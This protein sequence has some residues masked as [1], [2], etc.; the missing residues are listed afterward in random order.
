MTRSLLLALLLAA[1]CAPALADPISIVAAIAPFIGGTAAAFIVNYAGT[2]ALTAL[3][4]F[5]SVR[6]RSKQRKLAAQAKAAY[7][8]SLQDRNVSV[9]AA[10]P[11]RRYRLGRCWGGG[12]VVAVFTTDKQGLKENGT[13]YTKADGYKHVVIVWAYHQCSAIHDLAFEGVPIGPLDVDGWAIGSHWATSRKINQSRGGLGGVLGEVI[14]TASSTVTSV[15]LIIGY[16]DPKDASHVPVPNGGTYGWSMSGLTLNLPDQILLND[17]PYTPTAA[18]R[19]EVNYAREA[20]DRSTVRVRHHL[21]EPGQA[22][23]ALLMS[24]VPASWTAAHKGTGLCYSVITMDL[25]R[26]EFQSG[27]GGWTADISGLIVR[28]PRT[29]ADAWTS[30]PALLAYWYLQQSIG[31]SR[32][33]ADIDEASVIAAANACD[34]IVNYRVWNGTEFVLTPS[35]RY[36]C[37]GVI[38]SDQ[39]RES[40][41]QDIAESMAGWVYPSGQWVVQAGA[42]TPPV[43]DLTD[44]DLYGSISIVQSG[45]P[46]GELFNSVRG[47]YV[48]SN[49][50]V[51]TEMTPYSNPVFVA[52][53]GGRLW[54]TVELP[55][56]N[57]DH[58]A[59]QIARV[60][61]EQARNGET[62]FYPAKMRAWPLQPGDRVRVKSAEYGFDYKWFR[63]TDWSFG[64]TA[65]VG[66]TLQADNPEAYDLADATLLDPTPNTVL[67]SPSIVP[68][69]TGLA[70][71]SGTAELLQQAD[72]TITSRVRVSWDLTPAAYMAEGRIEI[73]WRAVGRDVWTRVDAAG[74]D[75]SVYITGPQDG[76]VIIVSVV[77][78]NGLR[79]RSP[80]VW[81]WHQVLG[82][83]EPPALASGLVL[84]VV[85][86]ALRGTL[87]T[88]STEL[89]YARTIYRYG[90][91]FAAGL[92][93]PGTSDK[94][95]FTW[96]SP[97]VGP[98]T[99]WYA[100]EDSSHNVGP[101]ASASITVTSEGSAVV[102]VNDAGMSIVGNTA[103]KVGGSDGVY[104]ASFRSR[105]AYAGGAFVSFVPALA[106]YD[107]G[108][109]L[110]TDPASSLG[111]TSIDWWMYCSAGG[112]LYSYVSGSSVLIGTWVP[113]D[114]L[115]VTY[116]GS[117]V[118]FIKNGAVLRDL[119][120]V[121]TAPLFIDSSFA[122]I[123][124]KVT[125]IQFGP[126]S[127]NAWTSVGGRPK[128]FIA[129]AS[130]GSASP[131]AGWWNGLRNAETGVELR[132][133]ARSYALYEMD[134][135]GNEVFKRTYDV[136]GVGG[137][138]G[139]TA[140]T[141]AADLTYIN[142][143]R[144]GNFVIVISHDEP[145]AHRTD[146]GL[147]E[148]MYG[149]GASRVRFGSPDFQYRSAYIL[150]GTAG[151]GEGG[152]AEF[153]AGK[154]G[155]D[156]G[157]WREVGFQLQNGVLNISGSMGG[158]LSLYDF[159]YVKSD[160]I[161]I[162]AL[163]SS[164]NARTSGPTGWSNIT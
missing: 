150:I 161:A 107:F 59:T 18:D 140:A 108:V 20:P 64:L 99:I 128:S 14:L 117:L 131:P 28:D 62:I 46:M 65:P 26:Q 78:V 122:T 30:N 153:Y 8:A 124:A 127:S 29:G 27:P 151:I 58:R 36:T 154:V 16:S 132:S 76:T 160:N 1:V 114:V 152:G 93:V 12:E 11:P 75:T 137:L 87:T 44:D 113:G 48:P 23:D 45:E 147:A 25:E 3:G 73:S 38:T 70:I 60:K 123:G 157:A 32:A 21:G 5:G 101:A 134:R 10:D 118:R 68:P 57:S 98:V 112:G 15:T 139:H 86:G 126:M 129:R 162:G 51:A 77:V 100:H 145:Q 72:G 141:M 80:E 85:P 79:F 56:T 88:P 53:D 163:V 135:A 156:P 41:L 33:A 49:T 148:A 143:N 109:G 17:A 84:S 13:S 120:A 121:I 95:G 136:Y 159:D 37:H 2:I 94:G 43:M 61:T 103:T 42:W 92:P 7:N 54:D 6:A 115:A 66:L 106:G 39:D 97:P 96:P 164:Y 4:V 119:A 91:S 63:V 149:A 89:D 146:S 40:V 142:V 9:L 83:T 55:F 116:D 67:P 34:E 110:N 104:D 82:K 69:I 35:P 102:L 81:E 158:A 155:A 22:A 52:G 125:N 105:D 130:G 19:W 138:D 133:V 144:K 111:Y 31:F 74:D 50:A 71:T 47:R 90:L 24:L